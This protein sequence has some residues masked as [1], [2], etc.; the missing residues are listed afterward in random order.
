MLS[1]VILFK[2]LLRQ[3][4]SYFW[5]HFNNLRLPMASWAEAQCMYTR[6]VVCGIVA[7]CMY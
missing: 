4:E 5:E 7:Q 1:N 6:Y 3:L 2:I